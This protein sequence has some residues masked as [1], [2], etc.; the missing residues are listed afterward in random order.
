MK[1]GF[2]CFLVLSFSIELAYPEELV[3]D[4]E[5]VQWVFETQQGLLTEIRY[6]QPQEDKYIFEPPC[7]LWELRGN[8]INLS[9]KTDSAVFSFTSDKDSW[10]FVWNGSAIKTLMKKT[11]ESHIEYYKTAGDT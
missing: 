7:S 8:G 5:M 1:I 4:G 3:L 11:M 10:Q 6:N 2:F 9:A